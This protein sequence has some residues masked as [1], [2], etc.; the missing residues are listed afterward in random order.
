VGVWKPL[1]DPKRGEFPPPA[2]FRKMKLYADEDIEEDA[3]TF[4]RAGGVNIKGA[5][6]I[7]HRGKPD[8][9]QAA[10]A[11]REKRFLLTRNGRDYLDDRA[12]PFHSLH[13]LIVVTPDM[14]SIREY[15]QALLTVLQLVPYGELYEGN[16]II[17]SGTETTMR[18]IDY[19]GQMVI[20]RVKNE[21]GR[22][23]V[24]G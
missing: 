17:V 19:Q 3:V 8:S 16:K 14:G 10:F 2:R 4:L 15:R 21:N 22:L 1:E 9:F 24:W 18:F 13:G 20:S 5:R 7:G 23:Y 12:F 6:E 11:K